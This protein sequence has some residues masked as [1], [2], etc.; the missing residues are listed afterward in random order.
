MLA[1]DSSQL[2]LPQQRLW[3]Y[4]PLLNP[5]TLQR[6]KITLK[7]KFLLAPKERKATLGPEETETSTPFATPIPTNTQAP[8]NTEP[9]QVPLSTY[10]P[11]QPEETETPIPVNTEEPTQGEATPSSPE[12]TE[13]PASNPSTT[14][15]YPDQT[16]DPI[17]TEEPRQEE[18]DPNPEETDIPVPP[19]STEVLTCEGILSNIQ[20]TIEHEKTVSLDRWRQNWARAY[21]HIPL[22][23][24]VNPT[25]TA[26]SDI[27]ITYEIIESSIANTIPDK[28]GIHLDQRSQ[29]VSGPP[30]SLVFRVRRSHPTN[31]ENL[32]NLLKS[33]TFEAKLKIKCESPNGNKSKFVSIRLKVN[34]SSAQLCLGPNDDDEIVCPQR[35]ETPEISFITNEENLITTETVPI[36]GG[37]YRIE[38]TFNLAADIPTQANQTFSISLP[39][40]FDGEPFSQ[41]DLL[42]SS[43]NIEFDVNA[44]LISTNPHSNYFE[45]VFSE[46]NGDFM[47]VVIKTTRNIDIPNIRVP[48]AFTLYLGCGCEEGQFNTFDGVVTPNISIRPR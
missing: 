32:F 15:T 14:E 48:I 24:V 25:A 22:S 6:A 31:F 2:G 9:E 5:K 11:L 20:D 41:S 17:G 43:P 10:R 8:I 38:S 13:P 34:N 3:N 4:L 36:G 44:H 28:W 33:I 18:T 12:E 42:T 7:I 29:I 47:E 45:I 19:T 26:N 35:L 46:R 37:D 39:I 30:E 21:T 27:V 16:P 1:A 40:T 23:S